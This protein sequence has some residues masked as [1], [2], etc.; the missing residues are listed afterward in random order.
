[1]ASADFQ[2]SS[3]CNEEWDAYTRG[4]LTKVERKGASHS[5]ALGIVDIHAARAT[6]ASSY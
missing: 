2:H 3:T 1:M 5:F 4:S 6:A